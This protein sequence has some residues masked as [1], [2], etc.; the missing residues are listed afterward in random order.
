MDITK[1]VEMLLSAGADKNAATNCG[2][3]P[4]SVAAENGHHR[5]VQMLLAAG[6]DVNAANYVATALYA[7]AQS[8]HYQVVEMLLAAGADMNAANKNG[9]TPLYVAA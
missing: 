1:V 6:A 5:V 2:T 7:A 9:V 8:E 3:T 4:I